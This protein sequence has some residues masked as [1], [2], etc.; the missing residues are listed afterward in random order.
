MKPIPS[1]PNYFASEDGHI[2]REGAQLKE[3]RYGRPYGRG[4]CK[5]AVSI[6]GKLIDKYVHRLVCE[7]YQGPCPDGMQCRHLDGSKTNN[8]PDNL[9]WG[10][11]AEN[12]AD[13]SLHSDNSH[14]R[15]PSAKL[16]KVIVKDMRQRYASGETCTALAKEYG[17]SLSAASFAIRGDTWKGLE[18][19]QRR[20]A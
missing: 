17:V 20:R 1:C 2:Y 10:T 16:T 15:N 9:C 11:T 4:Y 8:K 14:E 3:R 12:I 7:A 6:N 13:R 18:V 5:L 19:E